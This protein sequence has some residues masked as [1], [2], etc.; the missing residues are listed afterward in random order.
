MAT[1]DAHDVAPEVPQ[2]GHERADLK[3]GRECGARVVPAEQCRHDP[4]MGRAADRNEFRQS[5]HDRQDD[6]FDPR[7]MTRLRGREGL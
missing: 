4:Q 2:H 7:D 6:D 1:Q 3:H 5:L